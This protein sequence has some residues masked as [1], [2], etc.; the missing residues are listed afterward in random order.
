MKEKHTQVMTMRENNTFYNTKEITVTARK[1]T[2][3]EQR[4]QIEK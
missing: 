4:I 1:P 2:L 3:T